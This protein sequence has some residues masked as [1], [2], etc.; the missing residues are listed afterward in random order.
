MVLSI[1]PTLMPGLVQLTILYSKFINIVNRANQRSMVTFLLL[2]MNPTEKV[3]KD[4]DI[5]NDWQVGRR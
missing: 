4:K 3:N 2:L 1:A 5:A